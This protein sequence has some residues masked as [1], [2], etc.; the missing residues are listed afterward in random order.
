MELNINIEAI[1]GSEAVWDTINQ[2]DAYPIIGFNHKFSFTSPYNPMQIV[3]AQKKEQSMSQSVTARNQ[4]TH[5]RNLVE[6]GKVK[7]AKVPCTELVLQKSGEK[8]V[9]GQY[10]GTAFKEVLSY[11]FMFDVYKNDLKTLVE[12][13]FMKEIIEHLLG[14]YQE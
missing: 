8:K 4:F 6:T 14:T 5:I 3:E 2:P 9:T 10:K 1:L 13:D 7:T 11:R 12:K